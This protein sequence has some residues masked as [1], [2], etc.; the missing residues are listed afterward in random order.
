MLT[1]EVSVPTLLLVLFIVPI[2]GATALPLEPLRS[3]P[4][5][6]GSGGAS[7]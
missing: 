2:V 5:R 6:G 3:R 7:I 1:Y 4:D